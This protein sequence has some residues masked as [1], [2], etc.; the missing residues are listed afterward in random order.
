MRCRFRAG[1]GFQG[2]FDN[3][4]RDGLEPVH[5]FRARTGPGSEPG[6]REVTGPVHEP[7]VRKKIVGWD[8]A[9]VRVGNGSEA[10]LK[11]EQGRGRD[12][13]QGQGRDRAGT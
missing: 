2:H 10:E 5:V 7:G 8:R 6:F 12:L 3:P 13:S 11:R 4:R 1:P 9:W